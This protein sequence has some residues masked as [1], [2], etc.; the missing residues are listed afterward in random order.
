MVVMVCTV[1][2]SS[3]HSYFHIIFYT[4]LST[5]DTPQAFGA[6][7]FPWLQK[8]ANGER[9]TARKSV[10]TAIIKT[11][12]LNIGK[13]TPNKGKKTKSSRPASSTSSNS[14]FSETRQNYG[15]ALARFV[16]AARNC[17]YIDN[18]NLQP[19]E[20]FNRTK[21][22]NDYWHTTRVPEGP[23]THLVVSRSEPHVGVDLVSVHTAKQMEH[24][25]Q[26]LHEI[27]IQGLTSS[28]L[29]LDPALPEAR[30]VVC[31]SS[32]HQSICSLNRA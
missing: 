16:E 22:D 9:K 28:T 25:Y 24:I 21:I 17:E 23:R 19:Y 30:T 1:N 26:D 31:S 4:E 13:K 27:S 6:T 14:L 12:G 8:I 18:P 5:L 11:P 10:N 3:N 2:R 7:M 20:K 32:T 29:D 15:V